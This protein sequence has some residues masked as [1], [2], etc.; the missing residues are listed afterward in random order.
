[1]GIGS[2]CRLFTRVE[3]GLCKNGKTCGGKVRG[4]VGFECIREF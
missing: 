4:A 3:G 1:M 2:L